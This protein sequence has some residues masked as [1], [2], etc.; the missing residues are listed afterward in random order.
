MILSLSVS[1]PL[2]LSPS[3]SL[4]LPPPCGVLSRDAAGDAATADQGRGRLAAPGDVSDPRHGRGSLRPRG[5]SRS[6]RLCCHCSPPDDRDLISYNQDRTT[7]ISDTL[8]CITL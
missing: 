6:A 8:T 4:F 7:P 5:P 2:P 1:L 3:P